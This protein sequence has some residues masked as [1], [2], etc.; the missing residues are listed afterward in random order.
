MTRIALE[1]TGKYSVDVAQSAAIAL[2]KLKQ[3]S[4]DVIVSDYQMPGMD[5]IELLKKL[6]G[7]GN[8][9]PFIIFTGKGHEE[10]VIEAY[11]HGADFYVQK[12]GEPAVQFTDLEQ[13]ITRAVGL[14]RAEHDRLE[15]EDRL[16]QIIQFLPDATFAIDTDGRVIAW[17]KAIEEM[18]GVPEREMIGKGDYEYAI[19]F[20]GERRPILID[21]ALKPDEEIAK[22]YAFVRK[23]GRYLMAETSEATVKDGK[24]VLWGKAT[25]LYDTRCRITGA[26]E[27]IRDITGFKQTEEALRESEARYR[28]FAE[29]A[30]D[31][32]FRYEFIPKR[33]FTYV[34]PSATKIVGYTP[35]ELYA[36]PDIGWR[37]VHEEDCHLAESFL[38]DPG[39]F[40]KPLVLRW[41]KKDGSIIWTEQ[42]N[43]PVYDDDG[44]LVAIEGIARDITDR[45]RSEEA[46][47][48]KQIQLTNAMDLAHLVAWEYDVA[49]DLFTFNDS[50]YA[51][52]ATTASR[53]GGY[54]M[55]SKTYSD[56]FV[57]PDDRHFVAEEVKNALESEETQFSS[58][59]EH[60]IVRRDGET[61]HISVRIAGVLGESGTVA[62]TYGANQ[63]ITDSIQA[64]AALRESE[65]R[66]RTF[67]ENATEGVVVIQD[68]LV[69]YANPAALRLTDESYEDLHGTPFERFIHPDDREMVVERYQRRIRGESLPTSYDFRLV[70]VRG[71][72]RWVQLSIAV[73]TWNG[74]PATLNLLVDITERK[75]REHLLQVQH[76]IATACSSSAS[77]YD[78]LSECLHIILDFTRMDAG[79]I[80]LVDGEGG[81]RLVCASGVSESFCRQEEYLPPSSPQ[82]R[83]VMGGEALFPTHSDIPI[84]LSGILVS[85]GLKAAAVVPFT[86]QG[87]VV[88]CVNIASH[89]KETIPPEMQENVKT[90]AIQ[91]GSH[92]TR[93]QASDA[94]R[95]SEERFRRMVETSAEGIWEM[96]QDFRITYANQRMATILG[97]SREE[98][99]GKEI[100]SFMDSGELPDTVTRKERQR[101]GITDHFERKFVRKDGR[102]LWISASV[103]PVFD[104]GGTF[105]GSFAMYSDITDL[106]LIEEEIRSLNRVLEQRVEERTAQ[107][108]SAL[109]DR[110]IL[111]REVHH[112]VKNNL[113][114][115]ISLLNLQARYI[116]DEK[117]LAAIRES[118][119]RITAMALVHER[120][121]RSEEI[122]SIS[123]RDYVDFLVNSH[124]V[125]YGVKARR[126]SYTI[127]MEDLPIDIDTAIPL[128]LIMTEL[129]SNSLK[130]AFPEGRGGE[131]RIT[132]STEDDGTFRFTVSDNGVGIPETIDWRNTDSLGLRL[133]NSLVTQLNGTID[134]DRTGGTSFTF[135]VHPKEER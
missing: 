10:I 115:I 61:R 99:I 12:C 67:V 73:I 113:Q 8:S 107:L 89:A 46:I 9:T 109:K 20:Y 6:R 131:I 60:R 4:Y 34:S 37:C 41:K 72:E 50:F 18:T 121:Y 55:S 40:E 58:R 116:T 52:Y 57:H 122:S 132:G 59:I 5:G 75:Q 125:F 126:I 69:E 128:G 49:E 90:L 134:L 62:K 19:P 45:K 118:Q 130:Y 31:L 51:L 93:I 84:D 15:T 26:I 25:P 44:N 14:H 68:G 86:D 70:E 123:F 76:R 22:K 1:R 43:H 106:K 39:A 21:L 71:D 94:L 100:T 35:E 111:L 114:I 112:R 108:T 63:D 80:Y 78:I 135:I 54:Q 103:T 92:I 83:I 17:N 105:R 36:D 85:E 13:K 3:A 23:E 24:A 81:L 87:R 91:L 16:R 79:G 56:R 30:H 77:P 66:Y 88:G 133:V 97:Y 102:P 48:E 101:E 127:S 82:T 33:G 42:V 65:A 11:E 2:R 124:F 120:M 74:R 117:T 129:V 64:E 29:N 95:K 53:E 7:S 119:N 32:I 96:D 104:T 98:M 28:L 110:E 47:Q 27:S 38:R